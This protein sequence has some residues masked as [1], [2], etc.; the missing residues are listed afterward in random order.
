MRPA[1]KEKIAEAGARAAAAIRRGER[2][3]VTAVEPGNGLRYVLVLSFLA[4]DQEQVFWD[5]WLL[6]LPDWRACYPVGLPGYFATSYIAE[7][8]T[9]GNVLDA[10]PIAEFLNTVS[11]ALRAQT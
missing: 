3:I 11:E 4:A 2:V 9:H 8:L 7:K 1:V 6:S 5:Q 10:E